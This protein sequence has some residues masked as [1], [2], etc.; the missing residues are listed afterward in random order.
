MLI[1]EYPPGGADP[2]HRHDAN[3]FVYVLEGTISCSSRGRI[4]SPFSLVKNLKWVPSEA[5]VFP[6]QGALEHGPVLR[7]RVVTR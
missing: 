3:A 2:V 1:V 6:A 4:R 5:E 7:P